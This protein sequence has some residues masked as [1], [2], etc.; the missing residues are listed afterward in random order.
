MSSP[1]PVLPRARGHLVVAG[2]DDDDII[3]SPAP[4]GDASAA[5]AGCGSAPDFAATAAA[6]LRPIRRGFSRQPESETYCRTGANSYRHLSPSR[7]RVLFGTAEEVALQQQ[8]CAAAT[9][10]ELHVKICEIFEMPRT[11]VG[12]PI[13][14]LII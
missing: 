13:I 3:A 9:Q 12:V 2:A 7:R 8:G 1:L 14:F 4:L 5:L 10:K 11:T 6:I